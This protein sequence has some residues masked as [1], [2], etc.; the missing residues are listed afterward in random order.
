MP[1][2]FIFIIAAIIVA[3][4]LGKIDE[5]VN[6]SG[7]LKKVIVTFCVGIVIVLSIVIKVAL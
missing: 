2:Y 5:K 3:I 7:K 6:A 1:L 4:F